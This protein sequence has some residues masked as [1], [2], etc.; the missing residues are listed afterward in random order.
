MTEKDQLISLLND[1]IHQALNHKKTAISSDADEIILNLHDELISRL[2][3]LKT[4]ISE[5]DI[6]INYIKQF[7]NELNQTLQYLPYR[8]QNFHSTDAQS[9]TAFQL[10]F[11][12]HLPNLEK[13]LKQFDFLLHFFDKIGYIDENIVAIGA[14]GSGKSTLSNELK[15]LL[16]N[17]GVVISAQKILI[18]PT[19]S[20]IS[21]YS[22]TTAELKKVQIADKSL[23]TTFNSIGGSVSSALA[24]VSSEFKILLDNLLAERNIQ[25]NKFVD[26]VQRGEQATPPATNLD[27]TMQIWNSL[28]RHRILECLDGINITLRIGSPESIYSAYQMSD[29]EKVA[30]YL[31]AHVLQ[32]PKEGF[33]IIDEPETYLHKTILNKLWDTLE[34]ERQDCIFVYLTHDLDFAVSRTTAKKIWIKSFSHPNRWEIENI[35]NNELPE[36]ML[37]AL[38]GSRKNILFCEG[39]KGSIDEKIYNLIFPNL[40]IT[41]VDSC[42]DVISYTKAFNRLSNVSIKAIG[43]IDSD[44]HNEDRLAKLLTDNVFSF[45]VT[46]VENLFLDEIFL[47]KMAERLLQ[48]QMV[49][50]QIQLDVFTQ[51]EKDKELQATNFVATKI[52]YYFKDSHVSRGN[53]L[54]TLQANYSTFTGEIKI[55]DWFTKRIELLDAIVKNKDYRKALS[56]YNNKGLKSIVHRHFKISDFIERSIKLLQFDPST[57][58]LIKRYFPEDI[59]N[60]GNAS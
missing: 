8:F 32:A 55:N 3:F 4:F 57:H 37:M 35:P 9:K 45:A 31:I 48:D 7:Q 11:K 28:I 40:T 41:P 15:K 19:F 27:K 33:I 36:A 12:Q 21:N 26:A 60:A 49:V 38:L 50:E 43:L 18:I 1:T 24:N 13:Q 42:F 2:D 34:K 5:K 59:L 17:T 30:L 47:K 22:N 52:N 54:A 29:G 10:S 51:L 58:Q 39:Q 53:T 23:R 16:P 44:Y 14:N 25:R 46:E 20:G 56:V 6:P